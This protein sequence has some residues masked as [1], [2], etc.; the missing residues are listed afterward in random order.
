MSFIIS[1]TDKE[2]NF[3]LNLAR[4]TILKTAKGI[5][6]DPVPFFSKKLEQKFGVFVSL[7]I[8]GQL[9]GC[10]G[11]VVGVEP[12]QTAVVEMAKSAAF[13][14]PRFEPVNEKEVTDLQIEISVLSVLKEIEDINE[15]QVGV[16][17]IV[18]EKGIYKGLLL[19][20]VATEYNWDVETF[21]GHTCMKAGLESGDWKLKDTK[22]KIFS[23]E[24][25][26]E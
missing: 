11:Y 10:I 20:Q 5:D 9:R 18:I 1:L 26:S 6:P 3:L 2:K 14:D 8:V 12:L 15:I 24:I 16:H 25:F 19:P 13:H 17:G 23:A 21:L 4:D 22:I 7:H